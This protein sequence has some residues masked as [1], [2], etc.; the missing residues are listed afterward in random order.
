MLVSRA[1]GTDLLLWREQRF[2]VLFN[3][4]GLLP[5]RVGS[6]IGCQVFFAQR[7]TFVNLFF[8]VLRKFFYV[9]VWMR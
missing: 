3:E 6:E 1:A 9:R 7:L 5:Q 8:G 2:A 4:C